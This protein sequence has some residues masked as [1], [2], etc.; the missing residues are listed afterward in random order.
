[1]ISMPPADSWSA[2]CSIA[3]A[4]R[5]NTVNAYRAVSML[6]NALPLLGCCLLAACGASKQD[7]SRQ[8]ETRNAKAVDN[9]DT[10]SNGESAAQ[11]NIQLGQAYLSKGKLDMAMDKLRRGIE[12]AP[13]NPDGHTVIAVLYEQL[14]NLPMARKHY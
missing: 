9:I 11:I 6:R 14:G 13:R 10:S 2:R 5:V 12:L 8:S 7:F 4:D 1:M 3:R